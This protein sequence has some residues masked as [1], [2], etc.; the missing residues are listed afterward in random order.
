VI[1]LGIDPG[2][3]CGVARVDVGPTITVVMCQTWTDL[4]GFVQIGRMAEDLRP[5]I[6]IEG[7]EYQGAAKSRGVPHA[8]EAY[9][10]VAG[11]LDAFGVPYVTVKRGDVLSS[12]NLHRSSKKA[13]VRSTIRALTSG[14]SP[15]NDHEA[16]AVAVAIAGANR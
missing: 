11:I 12:L 15:R 2:R 8:A 6:A 9:G 4:S 7:W 5:L 10:R 14:A 1:W 16:D 13:S 3:K